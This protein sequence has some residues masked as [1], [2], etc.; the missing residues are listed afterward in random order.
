MEESSNKLTNKNAKLIRVKTDPETSIPIISKSILNDPI[1][2][3][4][5]VRLRK[6]G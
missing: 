1:F 6:K 5:T 4:R 2:S 3:I